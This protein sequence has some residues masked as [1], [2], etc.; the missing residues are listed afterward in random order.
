MIYIIALGT[1]VKDARSKE[2]VK[3]NKREVIIMPRPNKFKSVEE[4]QI[5]I[6][7]YFN[8]CDEKERPYTISGLAYALDTN[9]QTLLDYQEKDEFTDTIKKAKAKIE[10]FVEE[11][12]FMGSNTAGVIFNLKNNYDWK[13][14]QEIAADVNT[15]VNIK[16]ELTDD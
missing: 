15:D 8:E 12:L 2:N 16:I 13:D 4:M 6:D 5:A 11:R 3:K 7:N 10:Q 1:N 9:R 14:K